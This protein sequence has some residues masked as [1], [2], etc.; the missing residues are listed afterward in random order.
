MK[1]GLSEQLHVPQSTSRDP[2]NN[3][4]ALTRGRTDHFNN[5]YISS[6][7]CEPRDLDLL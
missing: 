5:T 1:S 2:L 4:N 3:W 6:C 7:E